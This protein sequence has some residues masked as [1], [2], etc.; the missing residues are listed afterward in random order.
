MANP[1][2]HSLRTVNPHTGNPNMAR[3]RTARH[4]T[5][6]HHMGN[7]NTGKL[8]M[9]SRSQ[10][11]TPTVIIHLRLMVSSRVS[12]G[13]RPCGRLPRNPG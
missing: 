9:V 1:S 6:N 3:H 7:R 13:H 8:H 11:S 2:T 10:V 5:A 12:Q 4:R